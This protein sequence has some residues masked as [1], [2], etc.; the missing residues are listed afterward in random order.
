[1]I[2]NG[3]IKCEH[4]IFKI[5]RTLN[6]QLPSETLDPLRQDLRTGNF[7]EYKN[8]QKIIVTHEGFPTNAETPYFSHE[9]YYA[10]LAN[11]R[12]DMNLR[13]AQFGSHILYGEVVT[14][15][16]TL[17]EKNVRLMHNLPH[18]LTAVATT[19]VAGRG[20]GS[21]S[22]ISPRGCLIF[23]TFL[24]HPLHINEHAP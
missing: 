20:R 14:S 13:G 19:Q 7:M 6:G 3:F 10:C 24:R 17:L 5:T 12:S 1:D 23:S 2:N 4:D 16:N 9:L 18:G 11:D 21:N 8:I 22:W 15:T